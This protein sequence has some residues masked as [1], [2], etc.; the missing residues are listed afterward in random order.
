MYK[1]WPYTD[2]NFTV[3]LKIGLP[4]FVLNR[5]SGRNWSK[6]SSLFFRRG[7]WVFCSSDQ[8]SL[9]LSSPCTSSDLWPESKDA[10]FCRN[11]KYKTPFCDEQKRILTKTDAD[12]D[13]SD[14]PSL[15]PLGQHSYRSTERSELCFALTRS[16]STTKTRSATRRRELTQKHCL[17]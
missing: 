14:E 9:G 16:R 11:E 13:S 7:F 4:N 1:S 5:S 17:A 6:D 10:E 8:T 15:P 12:S 2:Q 3:Y